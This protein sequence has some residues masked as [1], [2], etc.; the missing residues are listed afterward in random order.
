[1]EDEIDE[2]R[3]AGRKR[4]AKAL[5]FFV[6]Y[7]GVSYAFIRI[8]IDQ[9]VTSISTQA[10]ILIVLI[11]S[12]AVFLAIANYFRI[13][14]HDL[15]WLR[16][17]VSPAR[18]E[19]LATRIAKGGH[20]DIVLREFATELRF[21][22][23]GRV[24]RQVRA[25]LRWLKPTVE[26]A[27][28]SPGSVS[29]VVGASNPSIPGQ[30]ETFQY[31]QLFTSIGLYSGIIG[32]FF[33]LMLVF[34]LGPLSGPLLALLEGRSTGADDVKTILS[35]FGT[36]FLSSLFAYVGYLFTRAAADLATASNDD[37][38]S[39][40]EGHCV[41]ALRKAVAP[42]AERLHIDLPQ[43]TVE[44]IQQNSKVNAETQERFAAL[45]EH[46]S[47]ATE[48]LGAVVGEFA[49]VVT[50]LDKSSKRI[51]AA[52]RQGEQA[53]GQALGAW[54]TTT[55]EFTTSTG[56][57]A[58]KVDELLLHSHKTMASL[59]QTGEAMQAHWQAT[60]RDLMGALEQNLREYDKI[61]NDVREAITGQIGGL[62]TLSDMHKAISTDLRDGRA[63]LAASFE[64]SQAASLASVARLDAAIASLLAVEHGL[65]QAVGRISGQLQDDSV[66]LLRETG[67]ISSRLAQAITVSG[68]VLDEIRGLR[69]DMAPRR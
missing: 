25:F 43:T 61:M 46:I 23:A 3:S 63:Q 47:A 40:M 37:V 18:L 41:G 60:V 10:F 19:A 12:I 5:V 54:G 57:V 51:A 38:L 58:A 52:V 42:L 49:A 30:N 24:S 4:F 31:V 29:A 44:V 13:I 66:A 9:I 20:A 33:G 50:G 15:N 36:A 7:V 34:G 11:C 22:E 48:R 65:A 1:M 8:F 62:T 55:Q 6:V 69:S 28:D 32:T 67:G 21:D 53:W 64:R 26:H 35:G 39:Y 14:R 68:E 16:S 56:K 59:E 2:I 17:K 45:N 27:A